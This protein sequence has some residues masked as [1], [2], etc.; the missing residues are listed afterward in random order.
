MNAFYQKATT[1]FLIGYHFR[2]IATQK[3]SHPL[4]PPFEAFSHHIPRIVAFWELQFL[5]KTELEFGEFKLFPVHEALHIRRGELDRWLVLFRETLVEKIHDESSLKVWN[6]KL[7]HF[8][9]KFK[10]Y[11]FQD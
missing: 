4:K 9:K 7:D 6:S 5:G 11:F 3:G 8:E 2:K 1:D 10:E